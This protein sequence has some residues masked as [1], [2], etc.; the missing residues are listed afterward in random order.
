[1]ALVRVSDLLPRI[2]YIV[3]RWESRFSEESRDNLRT[4]QKELQSIHDVLSKSAIAELA[5]KKR[6]RLKRS[7]Q[8]VSQV[9]GEEYGRAVKAAD[10]NEAL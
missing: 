6:E 4:A 10:E 8:S 2:S 3:S 9:F 7:C 1:M 5:P